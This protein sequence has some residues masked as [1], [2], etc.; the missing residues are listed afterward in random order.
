LKTI[1][2]AKIEQQLLKIANPSFG[3]SY[4]HL[5]DDGNKIAIG[6]GLIKPN[7]TVPLHDHPNMWIST[8]VL[9]GKAKY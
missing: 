3:A 1:N 9:A 8:L 5:F 6:I 7:C 4:C 2:V